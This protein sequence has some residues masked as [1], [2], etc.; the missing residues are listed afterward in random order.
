VLR[1]GR[2]IVLDG[3][4][5]HRLEAGDTYPS[6]RPCITR[7]DLSAWS[8]RKRPLPQESETIQQDLGA[9]SRALMDYGYDTSKRCKF[10]HIED[11]KEW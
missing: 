11:K 10:N 5:P 6:S 1:G 9:D 4:T 2:W 3:E 7:I 8:L